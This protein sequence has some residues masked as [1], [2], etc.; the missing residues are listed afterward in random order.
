MRTLAG[1]GDSGLPLVIGCYCFLTLSVI[2]YL[3]VGDSWIISVGTIPGNVVFFV[4]LYSL[5]RQHV[6]EHLGNPSQ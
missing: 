4:A 6:S 1:W 2:I 5:I 3:F